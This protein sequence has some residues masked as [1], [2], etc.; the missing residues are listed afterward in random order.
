M[1]YE[2]AANFLALG[3]RTVQVCT[4]VMKYGLGVLGELESGLSHFMHARGINSINE[5]VGRA[6]PTAVTSFNVT[7][8]PR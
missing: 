2:S 5:L 1:S 6:H 8:E 4:V 7:G 3:A